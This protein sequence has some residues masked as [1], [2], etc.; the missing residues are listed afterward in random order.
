MMDILC[1][2]RVFVYLASKLPPVQGM[3]GIIIHW[4][5]AGLNMG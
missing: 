2:D 5:H 4:Q 1:S 3:A